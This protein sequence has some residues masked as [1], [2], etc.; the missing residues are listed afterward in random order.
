M[1]VGCYIFVCMAVCS[2]SKPTIQSLGMSVSRLLTVVRSLLYICF[3]T[4]CQHFN[5]KARFNTAFIASNQT[6]T[7][8]LA[9]LQSFAR[10]F[11][12]FSCTNVFISNG[13]VLVLARCA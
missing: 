4:L 13:V 7:H 2:D 11:L 9:K 8:T 5:E 3:C 6:Y 12:I 1:D 10:Y